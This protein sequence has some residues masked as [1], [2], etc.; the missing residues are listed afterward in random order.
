MGFE[1][2]RTQVKSRELFND[3][4]AMNGRQKPMDYEV[5]S[6]SGELARTFRSIFVVIRF[7]CNNGRFL[8]ISQRW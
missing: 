7:Q 4:K 5:W 6:K 1:A 3:D 2:A 8:N